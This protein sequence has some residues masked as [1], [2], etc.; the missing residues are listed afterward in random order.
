VTD[1]ED[2]KQFGRNC[3]GCPYYSTKKTLEKAQGI[4]APYQY[5]LSA[6]IL[7]QVQLV[8]NKT[9]IIIDEVRLASEANMLKQDIETSL[10][11]I[12]AVS[13]E[14]QERFIDGRAHKPLDFLQKCSISPVLHGIAEHMKLYCWEVWLQP[15]YQQSL[16]LPIQQSIRKANNINSPLYCFFKAESRRSLNH[17]KTG[18]WKYSNHQKMLINPIRVFTEVLN[19]CRCLVL[20]GSTMDRSPNS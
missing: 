1:I 8:G 4:L 18:K 15:L 17:H 11:A 7:K 6:A 12:A 9:V 14:M 16:S 20:T 2:I 3:G 13:R 10:A 5:V 19:S